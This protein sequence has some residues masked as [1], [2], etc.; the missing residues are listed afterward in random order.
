[1]G[2]SP[3]PSTWVS[4]PAPTNVTI[5]RGAGDGGSDRITVTFAD[6]SLKNQWLQVTVKPG[7]NT[8][9]SQPDVFYFGNLVGETGDSTTTARVDA[10][11]ILG[12][13]KNLSQQPAPVTSRYDFNR[14]GKV[15]ALDTVIARGSQLRAS[16]RLLNAPGGGGVA[17]A[18]VATFSDAPI[19]APAGPAPAT[20]AAVWAE[21]QPDLLGR[22]A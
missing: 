5:R 13:K 18:S 17:A 7:G 9:L 3:D 4:A 15:N 19:S 21:A 2:N 16:L 10:I 11:D 1:M 14:D 12:V 20:T 22:T 6:G 8:G